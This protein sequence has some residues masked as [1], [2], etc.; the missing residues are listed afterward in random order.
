MSDALSMECSYLD[1]HIKVMLIAPGTVRSNIAHNAADYEL[2][3]DS[4]FKQFTQIINKRNRSTLR[5]NAVTAEEFSRKVVPW[6]Q[7]ARVHDIRRVCDSIRH[8]PAAAPVYG[9]MDSAEDLEQAEPAIE[10]GVRWR[11][12]GRM[13]STFRT[14]S[15]MLAEL[16]LFC[17]LKARRIW[18]KC[19]SRW[20]VSPRG[21]K[22]SFDWLWGGSGS[23]GQAMPNSAVH[24]RR[25]NVGPIVMIPAPFFL[26]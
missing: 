8:H 11:G 18:A 17:L 21:S 12:F 5:G 19:V 23:A 4:L 14:C 16:K 7:P 13:D 26:F 10:E 24:P 3:P 6:M 20:P 2:F 25:Q 15:E 1:K 22:I 9:T